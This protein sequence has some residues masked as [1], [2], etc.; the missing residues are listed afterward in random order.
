MESLLSIKER[1]N[2]S[3]QVSWVRL[4]REVLRCTIA[5]AYPPLLRWIGIRPL[6]ANF[7]ITT[8]CSG[9][10][11][12]CTEWQEENHEEWTTEEIRETLMLL[13]KNGVRIVYFV[14]GDIFLRDDLFELLHF[15]GEL[16]LRIH[17][18][19]NAFTMTKKIAEDL[20]V[21][22]VS[23]IH[24]S[25]DALSGDLDELRGIQDAAKRIL[26]S[27]RLLRE[28]NGSRVQLGLTTTVMKYTLPSIREVVRFAIDND[29]TVFFNLINFSHHFF[30]TEFSREQYGLNATERE[31]LHELVEWLM[32]RH[33]E[34]P[35]LIPRLSHLNWIRDYFDDYR[36]QWPP[37]YQTLLK[38][39][40]RPNGDIRPCCSMETAGNLHQ[41]ELRTILRS[42][43][44]QALL[45]KA[46]LKECPGCSCRYTLNLDASL[47]SHIEEVLLRWRIGKNREKRKREG[48]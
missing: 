39:C 8:R 33:R 47:L 31:E 16:G 2:A 25:L 36:T 9:R 14:G 43:E 10:C 30:K 13:K 26:H 28:S 44:Y 1:I 6:Y 20:M 46:L 48:E 4:A 22:P 5:G 11:K 18:T 29:L 41:E 15:A 40:V 23:S 17:L 27:L 35:H 3:P 21:S 37:C 12:T 34:H 19:I 38:I 7:W 45:R 42:K 24:L 32:E